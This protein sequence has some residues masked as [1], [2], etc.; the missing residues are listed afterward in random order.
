LAAQQILAV[1]QTSGSFFVSFHTS[2]TYS[3]SPSLV[4]VS[5]C[6]A[7]VLIKLYGD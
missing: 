6:F 5:P 2:Q 1:I 3:R 7:Q 4:K